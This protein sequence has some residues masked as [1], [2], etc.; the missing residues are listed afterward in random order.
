ML[1][2]KLH[3]IFFDNFL[4]YY[5]ICII[6]YDKYFLFSLNNLLFLNFQRIIIILLIVYFYFNNVLYND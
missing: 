3:N 5:I 1:H 6:N 4:S 2:D